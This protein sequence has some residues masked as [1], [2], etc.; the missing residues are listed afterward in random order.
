MIKIRGRDVERREKEEEGGGRI[1]KE[2]KRIEE[3]VGQ[4]FNFY[5]CKKN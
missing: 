2:E 1:K 4:V 5:C 3:E